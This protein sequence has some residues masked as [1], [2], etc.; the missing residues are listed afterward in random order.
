MSLNSRECIG[1]YV[2]QST[3]VADSGG[4]LGYVVKL[5]CLPRRMMVR[6]RVQCKCEGFMVG[7]NLEW[8]SFQEMSE[9]LDNKVNCQ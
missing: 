9:M 6:T 3:Y 2:V 7:E 4:E 5:S 1:D 8:T